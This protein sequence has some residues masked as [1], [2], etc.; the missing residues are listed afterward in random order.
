[1]G[2]CAPSVVLMNP[3]NGEC[4]PWSGLVR[5][6]CRPHLVGHRGSDH[7]KW[8]RRRWCCPAGLRR[9]YP[10][11]NRTIV[12][13]YLSP[14]LQIRVGWSIETQPTSGS[15]PSKGRRDCRQGTDAAWRDNQIWG[16]DRSSGMRV[17]V[18]GKYAK[19]FESQADVRGLRRLVGLFP[20]TPG[21][22][23][24]ELQHVSRICGWL[25]DG[26]AARR[27]HR[28]TA[29]CCD[30]PQRILTFQCRCRQKEEERRGVGE[31]C[32]PICSFRPRPQ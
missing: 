11:T 8:T 16:F 4:R 23:D 14:L 24:G 29:K 7:E 19:L 13:L 32:F 22:V 25:K 27:S 1:M 10:P 12:V 9:T 6:R 15:T 26:R 28:D 30:K 17:G 3:A 2:G 5:E 20:H 31:K 21:S 18:R